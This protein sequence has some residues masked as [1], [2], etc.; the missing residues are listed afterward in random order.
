MNLKIQRL[1]PLSDVQNFSTPSGSS[2]ANRGDFKM[3]ENL[4]RGL[5][6]HFPFG[7]KRPSAV[8]DVFMGKDVL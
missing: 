7:C 2:F 5:L 8:D 1:F 6:G 4:L 3:D